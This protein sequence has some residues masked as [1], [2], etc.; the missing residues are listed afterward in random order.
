VRVP[1]PYPLMTVAYA[2]EA[3]TI[4]FGA[5][6]VMRVESQVTVKLQHPGRRISLP[7]SFDN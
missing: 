5:E 3:L 2:L 4:R 7:V 1:D 6:N